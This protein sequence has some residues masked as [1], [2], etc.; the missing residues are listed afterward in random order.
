[1]LAAGRISPDGAG[2]HI[3]RAVKRGFDTVFAGLDKHLRGCITDGY[4]F[5]V[6]LLFFGDVYFFSHLLPPFGLIEI[7]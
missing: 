2:L 7:I 4:R 6:D 3:R 5:D 1:V